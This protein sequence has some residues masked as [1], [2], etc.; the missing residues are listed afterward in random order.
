MS[1]IGT[2]IQII[3][4]LMGQDKNKKWVLKEYREKRSLSQNS[5]YWALCGKVA[6]KVRI[7]TA[8]LHNM[9]LRDLGLPEYVGDRLIPVYLPDTDEGETAA[10]E[11]MTYHIR[12]TSEVKV[13]KDGTVYR[14]Y[15]M[16]R[17]SH[18][19]NTA[20]MSALLDL[21][22]QEARQQG[23]ETLPLD[24][25]ERMRIHEQQREIQGK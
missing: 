5:C 10:L 11:A 3:S 14:C 1:F 18:T 20:E 7:S 2:A 16:L 19:F 25:I 12:P 9:L 15:V 4:F 22:I 8:R 13:G 24:E 23:I 6:R 21:M 17:G